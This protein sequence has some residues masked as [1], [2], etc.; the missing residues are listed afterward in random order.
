MRGKTGGAGHWPMETRVYLS[1]GEDRQR[2]S[3][4]EAPKGFV[5]RGGRRRRW[6][7]EMPRKPKGSEA[8][9]ARPTAKQSG[10]G[11]ACGAARQDQGQSEAEACRLAE[12]EGRQKLSP[13]RSLPAP[14]AAKRDRQ[15]SRSHEGRPQGCR[16]AGGRQ[17]AGLAPA[18]W[19][20][21]AP[22]GRSKTRG[23]GAA[24]E[25]RGRRRKI[26]GGIFVR[27]FQKKP[28]TGHPVHLP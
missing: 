6:L 21:K 16:S 5:A 4:A 22:G 19:K 14:R 25:A 12:P 20:P 18:A 15:G 28:N 10:A 23:A 9:E 1:G 17:G 27:R 7:P 13:R 26:K 3:V 11:R 2:R 8:R 24:P